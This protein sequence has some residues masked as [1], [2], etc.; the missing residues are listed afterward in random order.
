MINLLDDDSDEESPM[1]SLKDSPRGGNVGDDDKKADKERLISGKILPML[2]LKTL[3]FLELRKS[4]GHPLLATR[5][6]SVE[7][8]VR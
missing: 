2:L 3:A 7:R 5:E 8:S 4:R 1:A 6:R